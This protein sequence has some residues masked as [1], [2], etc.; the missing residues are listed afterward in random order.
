MAF[1]SSKLASSLMGNLRVEVHSCNFASVTTGDISVGM[2]NI[3]HMS[4]NNETTEAAGLVTKSGQTVTIASVTSNDV[5]T[6]L[7]IGNG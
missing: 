6:L 7:V 2:S 3:M 1:S 5:G 4:F